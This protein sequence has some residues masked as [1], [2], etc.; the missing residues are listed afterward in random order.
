ME[1]DL[2]SVFH[3]SKKPVLPLF[4]RSL[5][6]SVFSSRRTAIFSNCRFRLLAPAQHRRN[7]S[8][9]RNVVEGLEIRLVNHLLR[10]PLRK[11]SLRALRCLFWKLNGVS[12]HSSAFLGLQ[13]PS[14]NDRAL[15]RKQLPQQSER[16]LS[17]SSLKC[18]R[19]CAE[20][21][22]PPSAGFSA[23]YIYK[24]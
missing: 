11:H 1:N 18:R 19:R 13:M 7:T 24:R 6:T 4:W 20:Q 16:T 9:I 8:T 5:S 17:E 21:R 14:R 12:G 10:L 3:G 22:S 2:E 15:C 23:S